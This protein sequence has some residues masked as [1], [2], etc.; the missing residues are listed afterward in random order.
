M[1]RK[2]RGVVRDVFISTLY[3]GRVSETLRGGP[4]DRGGHCVEDGVDV[5]RMVLM[6]RVEVVLYSGC[7]DGVFGWQ[8]R[9]DVDE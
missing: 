3:R 6:R 8:E 1:G 5:S 9:D 7:E 4:W 2:R